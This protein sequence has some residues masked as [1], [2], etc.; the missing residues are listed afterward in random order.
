MA[1]VGVTPSRRSTDEVLQKLIDPYRQSPSPNTPWY[2]SGVDF[3]LVKSV[4]S[5]KK[6]QIKETTDLASAFTHRLKRLA[7]FL[8]ND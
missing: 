1:V 2:T 7:K 3:W 4:I 6:K 8:V 5:G